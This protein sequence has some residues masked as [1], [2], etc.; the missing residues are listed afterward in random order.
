MRPL[1]GT[2]VEL[3]ASGPDD[4]ALDAALAAG[5]AAIERA[6]ALWSFQSPV[7][8]LSRLNQAGGE[9]VT[10]SRETI[11]LLWLARALTRLSDGLFNCTVGGALVAQGVLPDHGGPPSLPMGVAGDIELNG[12][13][14]RLRRPVRLTLDGIA[15]GFAIDLAVSAMR[16]C[17]RAGWVNAGGDLRVFGEHALPVARRELDGSHTELG[18]LRQAALASSA[19]GHGDAQRF[20]GCIVGAQPP[21]IGVWSVVARQAWR[22]DALTKVAALAPT[23]ERSAWVQRLGG[24]LLA[25]ALPG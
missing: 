7:S 20:P 16:R 3:G 22:A 1:L 4:A 17:V 13:Q 2:F 25:P 18:S 10:Q 5:F 24:A 6:Q 12:M 19:V 23:A 9:A 11:R 21:A 15:K 8:E 14:A